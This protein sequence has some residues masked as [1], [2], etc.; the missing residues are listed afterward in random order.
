MNFQENWKLEIPYLITKK[1]YYWKTT[2]L[3]VSKTWRH[4][5]YI[6]KYILYIN[7]NHI[8]PKSLQ[9]FQYF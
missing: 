9:S 8:N 3:F 6:N 2:K 1:S 7:N 5:L 4:V